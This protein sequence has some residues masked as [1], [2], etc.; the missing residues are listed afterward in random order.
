MSAQAWGAVLGG[1]S[2]GGLLLVLSRLKAM[3]R[4]DL[5]MRVLPYI[6]DLPQPG[7]RPGASP[8]HTSAARGVFGPILRQAPPRLEEALRA[9][10]RLQIGYRPFHPPRHPGSPSC[11]LA[12]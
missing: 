4:S 12:G 10:P 2:A 9:R 8:A 7:A 11:C 1:L 3:R 6:R 5:S